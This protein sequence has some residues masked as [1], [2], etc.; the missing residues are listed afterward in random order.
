MSKYDNLSFLKQTKA[1]V[2]HI[3]SICGEIIVPG[4][5]YW[6]ENL[7]DKFLH[8]LHAK[9]YCDICYKEHLENKRII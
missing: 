3:C 1:R 4:E 5:I 8:N 2:E 9:K 7:Q 6:K